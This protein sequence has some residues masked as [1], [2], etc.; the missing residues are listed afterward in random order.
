V[1]PQERLT[2]ALA[3]I[4]YAIFLGVRAELKG[5][6]LTLVMPFSDHLVGNPMLPALH[7]GVVGALMELTAIT[8]LAIA[9]KSEK[10]PKTIDIGVDYL[11]SGRPL[12]TFA[13]A[14]VVKIGRRIANVQVEAWQGQRSQPIAAMHGHFLLA[15]DAE[16]APR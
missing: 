11:R 14:R 2:A 4:P 5:D 10:F 16:A 8:Q 1:T 13:R 15:E 12:D 6:E 3:R 9:S 7:G